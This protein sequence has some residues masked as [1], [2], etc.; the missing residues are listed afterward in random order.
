V[1]N[2]LSKACALTEALGKRFNLAAFVT[3]KTAHFKAVIN[4]GFTL[5][6]WDKPRF[7]C[8]S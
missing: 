2:C 1:K 8:K 6:F 3:H 5:M 4:Y 7:G